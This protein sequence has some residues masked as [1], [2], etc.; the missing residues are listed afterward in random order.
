MDHINATILKLLNV[1]ICEP[2][3]I[4]FNKCI[5]QGKWPE[6]FKRAEVIPIFKAGEKSKTNNYRPISLISNLAKIFERM[7]HNRFTEFFNEFNIISN[8]QFGFRKGTGCDNA[9]ASITEFIYNRLDLTKPVIA[10]FLDLVK[11]FDTVNHEILYDKLYRLGIRGLALDLIK[12]YL[13]NRI[14]VVN[15]NGNISSCEYLNIGVPQ[16]SILGPLLFLIYIND[17]LD[18]IPNCIIVS[19]AD[20]T[21]TLCS[22]DDWNETAIAMNLS[23]EQ[24]FQWLVNNQLT[25]NVQKTVYITFAN[26]ISTLPDNIQIIINDSVLQNVTHTKYLGVIIDRHL[27]WREHINDICNRT[28]Y[29]IFIFAKLKKNLSI[30]SLI[31]IYYGLFHSIANYGVIGWGSAYESAL[32]PLLMLQKRIIKVIM[33]STEQ[34]QNNCNSCQVLNIIQNYILVVLVYNYDKL[35][36]SYQTLNVPTRH[37]LL[38]LPAVNKEVGKKTNMYTAIT[39]YNT[40]PQELKNL[41]VR[42]KVMK[43]KIKKWI[44]LNINEKGN[45]K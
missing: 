19:H 17:L 2:L 23:L 40:L 10:T 31:T 4:I 42:K 27:R 39:Y 41:K 7:I 15:V 34:V 25:I 24:V 11:A 38:R 30:K 5:A 18:S 16:G 22:E 44:L 45:I 20:D 32:S 21:V 13:K 28:K 43:N 9:L 14:Q 37:K 26:S 3:L 12:S 6:H 35:T 8:N 36:S 33:Q 1:N 29:L